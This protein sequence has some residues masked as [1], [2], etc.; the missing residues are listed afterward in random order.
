[1]SREHLFCL[2]HHCRAIGGGSCPSCD[3]EEADAAAGREPA[4]E[5]VGFLMVGFIPVPVVAPPV[6]DLFDAIAEGLLA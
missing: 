3:V 1:M 4:P 5:V 2:K 6:R